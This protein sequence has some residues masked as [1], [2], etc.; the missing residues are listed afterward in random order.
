MGVNAVAGATNSVAIGANSWNDRDDTVSVGD[1]GAERQIT[2]VAAGTEGTDAVNL[3]QLNA[4]AEASENATRY[5]KANGAGDGSDDATATG[6][7]A[8]ASGAAALAEGVGATATGSGAFAI[9]NG[10][11]AT[12]FNATATGEN[13]V[14]SGAGAQAT[15]AGAVAL[16]GQRPLFDE[17]GDPL[18]DE[19]GN[20]VYAGTEATA[21]DATA[22]GAGA[23]ASDSGATQKPRC[24]S[25]TTSRSPIRRASASRKGDMPTA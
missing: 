7:Y 16:G 17:N 2:N 9:A 22:L 3:D 10:A 23:V 8:T 14:A 18:L 5:F 13:S 25:E 20:P 21:D 4:L 19:D 6:D 24:P 1:V 12:G 15:G 11:T